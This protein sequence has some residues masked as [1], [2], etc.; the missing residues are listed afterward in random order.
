MLLGHYATQICLDA[1][2][3]VCCWG[4][5]QQRNV[6][7]HFTVYAAGALCK[8][9]VWMHLLGMLLGCYATEKCLDAFYWVCCWGI[10]Q[11]KNV[12]M[13]FAVY[14]AG[15]LCNREMS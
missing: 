10:M 8:R 11:Q 5:M 12:L 4:V 1:F 9:E 13:H 3:W 15:A 14:V 6:L 7:M 2:Y